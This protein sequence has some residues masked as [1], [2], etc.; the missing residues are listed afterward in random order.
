MGISKS[1]PT[2]WKNTGTMPKG[3]ILS[4]IAVYFGVSTDYLLGNEKSAQAAG[5]EDAELSEEDMRMK[6]LNAKI[7]LLSEVKRAALE[8][9]INAMLEK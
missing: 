9:I 2:S 1:L 5:G 7:S 8:E 4:K 3:E 6:A